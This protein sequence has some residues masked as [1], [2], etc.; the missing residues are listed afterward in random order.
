MR[1]DGG[2]EGNAQTLRILSKLEKYTEKHGANLTRRVLLGV[3]KYP[4]SYKD[5][6]NPDVTPSGGSATG[7]PL[8]LNTGWHPPKC[9]F[10]SDQDVVDW[11]L[12]PF[13]EKDQKRFREP[14]ECNKKHKPSR[15]KSLDCSIMDLADDISYGVH[16]LEDVSYLGF[17]KKADFRCH[18]S[19]E[20]CGEFLGYMSQQRPDDFKDKGY[21]TLLKM[22]FRD[23]ERA[24]KKI[25]GHLIGY[26]IRKTAV[27]QRVPPV[28][29]DPLLDYQVKMGEEAKALLEALKAAT[30]KE[31][32]QSPDVQQLV[33][34]G[35][36]MVVKV[37]DA[38]ASDP[39]RFL[40]K[41]TYK[42]FKDS[43]NS[44]RIICDHIAGMTD[45]FFVQNV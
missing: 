2:F 31:V 20:V 15:Y 21:E 33:F 16:D 22:L 4:I 45:H 43:G 34:K 38:L 9:Y 1:G 8:N 10:D 32:V 7:M 23:N 3:L 44:N 12:E 39:K 13:S 37:F 6:K 11:I 26:F 30:M 5:A 27:E 41:S 35:Q 28:F 25:I 40:L 24:R 36:H 29:E 17:I 19:E 18:V 14:K 42:K